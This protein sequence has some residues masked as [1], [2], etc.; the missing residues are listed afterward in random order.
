MSE[1]YVNVKVI[2]ILCSSTAFSQAV[3]KINTFIFGVELM[4]L[5]FLEQIIDKK[6][7]QTLSFTCL[8]I[9]F[10]NIN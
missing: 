4:V 7:L 3:I 10:D 2:V 1:I 9:C 6:I 5:K 8:R